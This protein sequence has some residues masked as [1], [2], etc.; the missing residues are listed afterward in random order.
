MTDKDTNENL[1]NV[2]IATAGVGVVAGLQGAST[3]A[4]ESLLRANSSSA[5]ASLM[6]TVGNS[7]SKILGAVTGAT[8]SLGDAIKPGLGKMTGSP[9]ALM[10][11]G[12]ALHWAINEIYLKMPQ[13][14]SFFNS[15]GWGGKKNFV[16]TDRTDANFLQPLGREA[17]MKRI[18]EDVINGMG[19]AATSSTY[20]DA[21]V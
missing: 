9:L 20:W 5:G 19:R 17:L 21:V 7:A 3:L 16:V 15:F 8:G 2:S 13:G 11:G 4:G 14:D 1:R 6:K 12:F 18:D 10:L